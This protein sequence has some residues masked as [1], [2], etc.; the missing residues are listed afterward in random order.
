[1]VALTARA[2]SIISIMEYKNPEN[3]WDGTMK[4]K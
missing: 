1:M 2:L 4:K 3:V